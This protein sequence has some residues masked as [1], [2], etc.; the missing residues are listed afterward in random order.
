MLKKKVQK[1]NS[2][3]LLGLNTSLRGYNGDIEYEA[4]VQ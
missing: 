2:P 1:Y 3:F 4:L